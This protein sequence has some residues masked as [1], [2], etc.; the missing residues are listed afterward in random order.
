MHDLRIV[1]LDE[2]GLAPTPVVQCFVVCGA[3]APLGGRAGKLVAIEVQNRKDSAIPHRIKKVNRLPAP[4]K[5]TGLRFTV[6]NYAGNDQIRIVECR[7]KGMNQRIAELS[8][9]MHG[10][11]NV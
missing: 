9:L 10:V 8:T 5:R 3:G 6:T 11:S 1:S 4:F 7:S 2:V